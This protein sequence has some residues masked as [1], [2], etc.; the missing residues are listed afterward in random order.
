M[1]M[2]YENNK[3]FHL[4]TDKTSYIIKVLPSGHITNLHYGRKIKHREN[5]DSLYQNFNTPVGLE[6]NY[7]KYI[8]DFTLN[9]TKLELS[10]YGKGDFKEPSIHIEMENGSRVS[11]FIYES[12]KIFQ[13]K[14]KIEG[15]P[16][17]FENTTDQKGKNRDEVNSLE[18]TMYDENSDVY[19]I[20]QYSVFYYKDVITRS[21]RIVNG[22][23]GIIKIHKAMS[24]NIDLTHEDCELITLEGKWIREKHIQKQALSK[25]VYYLDSKR[26]VSGAD[27]NPF[28]SIKKKNSDENNG[29]CYGFA[30]IYSGNHQGLVEV[31]P[32][33][34]IRLQMGINPFDFS[35]TLHKEEGFQ[36]P[37]VIMTFSYEG[38]NKL[39]RNF[40]N[41][42]NNNVIPPQWQ[43]KE[44][45][46]IFNSWEAVGFDFNEKKLLNLARN[47]KELGMELFVLD[48][49]WFRGR[50]DDTSSLGDWM[51]DDKKLPG[52]LTQLCHRINEIGLHFGLWVEPEM[53]SEKSE[54]YRKHPEWAIKLPNREPSLG[55][56]QLILDMTNPEVREYLY[57]TLKRIFSSSNIKYVKWDMNRSV[58]DVYSNYLESWKQMEFHHRYVLG[59]YELIGRIT[60]E[61]P[62]ILFESCASGGNRY[63]LGMLYYMPQTWAS[64]NTD[65]GER[66]N[67]QYGASLLYPQSTLGAH[68]GSNPSLQTLRNNSIESRFN[69]AA[70]GI[71][72]YEL[73]IT[74]ISN[75]EGKVI[76]KQIEF[77]K[78]HRKLFQFGEF[79]RIK[80]PFKSNQSILMVVS[81]DKNEGMIG[82][83][84]KLQESNMTLETIKLKGLKEDNQYNL[85]TREQ[86]MNIEQFGELINEFVPFEVRTNGLK[87]LVHKIV[88]D[89]YLFKGENQRIEAYGDE[90]MYAGFKPYPQFNGGGYNEKVRYIGDFGSRIYYIRTNRTSK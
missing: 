22:E 85:Y 30:L 47:A 66:M 81:E 62:H 12:H 14:Y 48:D 20:L 72:G 31:N 60:K 56:N 74:K 18:I 86:F 38:L 51:V 61:F 71:L 33:E 32:H 90:L 28:M 21:C 41:I 76:K 65:A 64:D 67:I 17:T 27:H 52:G 42:I 57:K 59:V 5:F 43:H 10:T 89:N 83:Y 79:Y 11:D 46:I 9:T 69:V 29:E 53:I 2:I 73:D 84:Q 39:S 44:R 82:Y 80:S 54:R 4:T 45:S 49:G 55:R 88:S 87:G 78:K 1:K 26:G 24:M 7:S 70:F 68:V 6:V 16:H 3:E 63:D 25:G 19:V 50:N 36:T 58:T 35:W 23:R 75:F 40:H 77:Y 34:I 37:E 8:D 13:G 15:L